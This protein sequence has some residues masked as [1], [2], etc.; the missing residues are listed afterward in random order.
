MAQEMWKR[1]IAAGMIVKLKEQLGDM[2]WSY[3]QDLCLLAGSR[4]ID[5]QVCR[6]G[7]KQYVISTTLL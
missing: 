7:C 2:R 4:K 3:V 6:S 5:N 1:A